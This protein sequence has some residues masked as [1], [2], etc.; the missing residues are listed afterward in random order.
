MITDT[1]TVEYYLLPDGTYGVV[2]QELTYGDM[3]VVLLLVALLFVRIYELWT[4][5]TR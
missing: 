2:V 3:A 4:Q 5:S 1:V